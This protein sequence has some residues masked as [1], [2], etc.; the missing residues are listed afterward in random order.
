MLR[1][2]HI[3][4]LAVLAGASVEFGPGLNTLTGETGAGKSIVVDSLT[5]LAGGRASN[6]L[7]RTGADRLTVSGVFT[8]AGD[9]WLEILEEAGLEPEELGDGEDAEL[10]IRREISRNG[11]NR[12]YVNDQP[13]TLKLLADLAPFLLRI[14]GQREE[15]ELL[16]A[17]L[18]RKWLDRSG[19]GKAERLLAS[20]EAAYR[21]WERLAERLAGLTGDQRL[22]RERIDLLRF[23][24]SEIDDA[25]ITAGEEEEL[26]SERDQLRNREA[27]HDALGTSLNLLFEDDGAATERLARA[28]GRL[29]EIS[30]WVPEAA[31]WSREL[32]E[33][34]IRCEELAASLRDHLD[35]QD[36]DPGRLDALESRLA[37]LERLFRKYGGSSEAVLELRKSHA[38]ELA[39]LEGDSVNAGELEEKAAAALAGYREAALELSAA[40]HRWGEALCAAM[41][42]ELGDL[43]LGKA[44]LEVALE[45]RR[46]QGSTLVLDGT[47]DGEEVDFGAEGVDHVVFRFSPNPGEAAQPLS[48]IASGGELSR[49][50]LALQLAAGGAGAAG[51]PTLVFDEVDTGV[52]GAQAAAIGEKLH[53]LARGGQILAVTHLPQVASWGDHQLKVSKK[54]AKGRTSAEVAALDDEERVQEIARMLAGKK[55]TETSLEHARELLAAGTEAV[56]RG[57]GGRKGK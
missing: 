24:L 11:R 26:R 33:L 44:R 27:I 52:G 17:S 29:E 54:V 48:R 36:D 12:A 42:K 5:L 45:R 19:G 39:E 38:A 20:V 51:R 49:L 6:D 16:A 23:Q 47:A 3:R 28:G 40:R 30:E 1:E 8:P 57:K 31:D 14:H 34:R 50:S 22:R 18:Q 55:V 7:I 21:T 41:A 10:L 35:E 25:R 32:D 53:R 43:G 37:V 9:G 2:L 13:T 4:N 46:R 15:S 56:S